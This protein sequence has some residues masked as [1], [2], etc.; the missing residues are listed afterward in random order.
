[1]NSFIYAKHKDFTCILIKS[2]TILVEKIKW[3]K[4]ESTKQRQYSQGIKISA[5]SISWIFRSS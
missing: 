3:L 5:S 4:A 2:K 1:M